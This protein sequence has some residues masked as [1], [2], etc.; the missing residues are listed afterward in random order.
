MGMAF[1][2]TLIQ[3]HQGR[4]WCNSTENVGTTFYFSISSSL[5]QKAE[6]QSGE[7]K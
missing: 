2:K 3:R 6:E 4:V 5:Q 1:I 7:K